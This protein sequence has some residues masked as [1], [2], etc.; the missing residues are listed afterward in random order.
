MKMATTGKKQTSKTTN[1]K[2][3]ETKVQNL[4]ALKQESEVEEVKVQEPN[5]EEVKVQEPNVEEKPMTKSTLKIIKCN[6]LNLRS[7][8][9]KN[10]S[11]VQVLSS[12]IG[13][14]LIEYISDKWVKVITPHG[15]KGYVMRTYVAKV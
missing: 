12:S 1:K 10:A 13:L 5:V 9:E 7:K 6:F 15:S 3:P 2:K 4:E 11:I 14:D 8:P